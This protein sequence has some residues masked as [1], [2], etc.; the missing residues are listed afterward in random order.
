PDPTLPNLTVE[1]FS[2][3]SS[4]D[5]TGPVWARAVYPSDAVNLPLMVVQHG[6]GSTRDAVMYSAERMALNG[7]FCIAVDVRGWDGSAGAHDDGGVEI[8]DIY[9][10]IEETRQLY[11]SEVDPNLVSIIGYSNGGG[12]VFFSTVRFPFTFRASMALFGVVDYGQWITLVPNWRDDVVAAVGGTPEEL[13]D[14]YFVRRSEEAASNL[15][16]THFHIAYDETE[17]MCPPIMD[18][19]FAAAVTPAQQ[20]N[21]FVHISQ[22]TDPARWTH[23]HNTTGH[24]N[25]IEDL[26]MADI[27][28]NNLQTPVMPASGSLVLLVFIVTPKFSCFLANGDDAAATVDYDIQTDQATF[29]FSPLTSDSTVTGT[30]TLIPDIADHD[31]HVYIDGVKTAVIP[32]GAKLEISFPITSSVHVNTR[33]FGMDDLTAMATA[34]LTDTPQWDIAPTLNGDGTVNLSDFADFASR[35]QPLE[36]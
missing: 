23:A 17:W 24:L 7:F 30:L 16:G 3:S 6:Y 8:M 31:A 29:N 27:Y 34:W 28:D 36:P 20:E 21:L 2:F 22:S 11:P 1:D 5:S 18:Q 33:I 14:H 25:V 32:Q 26:F 19:E 35:W 15:N 4:F 10:A 13:P 12:N 9:D